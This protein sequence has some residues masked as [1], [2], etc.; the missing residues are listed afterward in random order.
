M[1]TVDI[2]PNSQPIGTTLIVQGTVEAQSADNSLRLLQAD[3][4]VFLYDRIITG[5]NGTITILFGDAAHTQLDLGSM[6]DVLLDEDVFPG[7]P[8][9]FSEATAE[10]EQIQEALLAGT[11]DPATDLEP[12]SAGSAA[13][14]L[15][16][17]DAEDIAGTDFDDTIDSNAS[18]DPIVDRAG[19]DI[20]VGNFG[21]DIIY[22]DEGDDA[23]S[24]EEGED[25]LVDGASEDNDVLVGDDIEY[26]GNPA[27]PMVVLDEAPAFIDG[28]DGADTVGDQST[29]DPGN[30]GTI[31]AENTGPDIDTLLAPPNDEV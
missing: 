21:D 12:A 15:I 27:D 20:L 22:G 31:T 3:S 19:E 10:V 18:D 17:S 14:G 6:S 26:L 23:L 9:D 29:I 5:N 25:Q 1:T 24:G 7:T 13:A 30:D 2:T 4:P 28:G 16:I 8:T 11:F